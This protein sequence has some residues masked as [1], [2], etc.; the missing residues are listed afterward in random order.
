MACADFDEQVQLLA[1]AELFRVAVVGDPDA[2]DSFMTKHGRPA[3]RCSGLPPGF[4]LR[5][6]SGALTVGAPGESGRGLPQSK[7]LARWLRLHSVVPAS[8]T[9]AML[10]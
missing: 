4:G 9:L 1:R 8:S 10:G 3:D 2:S 6:S 7:T 5:E